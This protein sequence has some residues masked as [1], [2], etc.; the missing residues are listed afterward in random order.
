MSGILYIHQ[1]DYI[2][3]REYDEGKCNIKLRNFKKYYQIV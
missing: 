1:W 2:D 3:K